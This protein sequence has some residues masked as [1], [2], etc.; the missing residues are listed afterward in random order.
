MPLKTTRDYIRERGRAAGDRDAAA[1]GLKHKLT[2]SAFQHGCSRSRSAWVTWGGIEL[3]NFRVRAGG[4]GISGDP[5]W[6]EKHRRA[7]LFLCFFCCALLPPSWPGSGGYR[8]CHSP[9][10][11]LT[12]LGPPNLLTLKGFTPP[13]PPTHMEAYSKR[14]QAQHGPLLASA[15]TVAPTKW[16]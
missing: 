14:P 5:L 15:R 13:T 4:T 6:G 16:P 8:V 2:R 11:W 12:P 9:L 7:R 1:T 3:T 10:T